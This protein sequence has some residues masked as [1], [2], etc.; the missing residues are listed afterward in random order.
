MFIWNLNITIQEN[1]FK[2]CGLQNGSHFIQVYFIVLND[3]KL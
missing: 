2:K 3:R 1:A